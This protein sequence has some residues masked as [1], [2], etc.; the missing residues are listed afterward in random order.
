MPAILSFLLS[1][2]AMMTSR[3]AFCTRAC[4][5]V[6]ALT[7]IYPL[8][9]GVA[10]RAQSFSEQEV[11]YPS[12]EIQLAGTVFLPAGQG[13]HP[14]LVITHGSE[15]ASR[16]NRGYRYLG[17]ELAKTGFAVLIYDK[18]G[19]DDS[20]GTYEETPFMKTAA[21][22]VLAGVA[23]LKEQAVVD[24]RRIGVLGFSQGGWVGPLAA[25]LSK[26]VAFVVS[27]VGPGVSI[28]EQIIYHRS[29]QWRD[30]GR[31]E[32][33]IAEMTDFARRL[34][35]YLGTGRGYD[36]LKPLYETAAERPWFD[37]FRA[38]GFGDHL[39]D[40]TRLSASVFDFFRKM[41]YDPVPVLEQLDV[42]MLALF[43]S[44]DKNVPTEASVQAMRHAFATS[45]HTHHLT[46]QVLEG[47]G[48]NLW[49][50]NGVVALKPRVHEAIWQWLTDTVLSQPGRAATR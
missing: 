10:A 21:G 18:R 35:I 4:Q 29:S 8:S 7:L 6:L 12:G 20:E 22:D 13:P 43:G 48:H 25:S 3:Y 32:Q 45:G 47:I 16:K 15:R 28:R 33:E 14:A 36:A 27:L 42:P 9:T 34:Y 26:D 39:P 31:T 41:K 49:V 46:I 44:E 5:L 24:A 30:Q 17:T 50:G 38:E 37:H 2:R 1:D 11:R 19:V 40:T 23:V